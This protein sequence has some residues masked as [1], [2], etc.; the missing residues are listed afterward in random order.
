[1]NCYAQLIMD[2]LRSSLI[3]TYGISALGG[4]LVTL[5][6]SNLL[7]GALARQFK[8]EASANPVGRVLW[9]PAVLGIIE[10]T[11]I[12]TFV[13]FI[14]MAVGPFA[15]AWVTIKAVGGW[16]V[17]KDQTSYSRALFMTGL[18]GSAMSVLWAIVVGLLARQAPL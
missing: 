17:F 15:G 9:I 3:L 1:M 12:T 6:W 4:A 11:L 7:H 16:G 5:G 2:Y 10:R 18:L 14:P 8:K 13:L